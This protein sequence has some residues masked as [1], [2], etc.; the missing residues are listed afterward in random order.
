M[1][2]RCPTE[3]AFSHHPPASCVAPYL[4]LCTTNPCPLP[5]PSQLFPRFSF[6][7]WHYHGKLK[8]RLFKEARSSANSLKTITYSPD[9]MTMQILVASMGL[10]KCASW[11]SEVQSVSFSRSQEGC[12]NDSYFNLK[13]CWDCIQSGATLFSLCTL[14]LV[15]FTTCS[16]EKEKKCYSLVFPVQVDQNVLFLR[17]QNKNAL[18]MKKDFPKVKQ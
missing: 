18:H 15:H 16:V 2:P 6:Y 11:V 14:P 12:L 8:P 4:H 3:S 13:K 10:G 17:L 7:Q 5:T 9:F 1:F